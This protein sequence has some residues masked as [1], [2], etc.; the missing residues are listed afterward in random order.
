MFVFYSI[1][2]LLF[3]LLFRERS[4]IFVII[5]ASQT[6]GYAQSC[7]NDREMQKKEITRILYQPGDGVH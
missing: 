5:F 2:L 1:G 7:D 3:Y 4:C 6:G